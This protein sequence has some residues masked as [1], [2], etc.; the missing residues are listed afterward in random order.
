MVK[1]IDLQAENYILV[2]IIHWFDN[3]RTFY[4]TSKQ[5]SLYDFTHVRDRPFDFEG[6]MGDLVWVRIFFPI[7]TYL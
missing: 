2:M 3:H 6:G 1:G 4:F 5:T 7:P